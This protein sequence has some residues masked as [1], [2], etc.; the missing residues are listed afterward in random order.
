M[1]KVL[2]LL[3]AVFLFGIHP[4]YAAQQAV[5]GDTAKQAETKMPLDWKTCTENT[6]CQLIRYGCT[7][8]MAVNKD[9]VE[10]TIKLAHQIGDDPGEI[11]CAPNQL[12]NYVPSCVNSICYATNPTE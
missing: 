1:G 5:I 11:K 12:P 3:V 8:I 6:D 2:A 10:G 7:G 9:H 4:S